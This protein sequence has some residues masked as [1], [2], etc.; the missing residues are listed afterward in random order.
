[1]V[2]K[3]RVKFVDLPGEVDPEDNYIIDL[4]KKRYEIEFSDDPDFVFYASFGYLHQ[5]Y[6]NSVRIFMGGEPVVANF[7]DCDYAFGH[8]PIQFADRYFEAG[9]LLAS[10]REKGIS[11]SIQDRSKITDDLFDRK[12]CNFVYSLDYGTYG[13]GIR[14]S[15]C[16][17]LMEEYKHV[18]CPG[19]VLNNMPPNSIAPRWQKDKN[20]QTNILDDNEWV[21]GKIEFLKQYKFTIA[22]ENAFMHGYTTEKLL[23]P[24]LASSI[25]IYYGNP[26]VVK[27]YNPKSF[28]NCNDYN[29]DFSQV[30]KRIIE[31]DNDRDAYMKMLRQKPLQ[32]DYPFDMEDRLA[33]FLY[34][35]IDKGRVPYDKNPIEVPVSF[36]DRFELLFRVHHVHGLDNAPFNGNRQ[37]RVTEKVNRLFNSKAAR[38]LKRIKNR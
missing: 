8:A 7:N 4:L 5:L 15:F 21:D 22:F 12:F 18:D 25:P 32:P 23:D 14:T 29:N 9:P 6:R 10:P 30:I 35:I 3:I 1:M 38:L 33:E 37:W 28:I 34:R 16:R 2:E 20:N 36:P 13:W 26:D 27:Y 17:K 11:P 31:L 19:K 24:M